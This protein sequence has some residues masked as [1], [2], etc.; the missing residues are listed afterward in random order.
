MKISV[1]ESIDAV[2]AADWNSLAHQD[3]PFLTHE[4]LAALERNQCVG[5]HFGWLPR[6]LVAKDDSGRLLGAVPMYL[7]F[8]SYGEF[9]FDWSWADAYARHGLNYYPKLV[10]GIPYTP[11]TGPR[12]LIHPNFVLD[13]AVMDSLIQYSI[14]YAQSLGVSS[15]HWLFPV[16]ND[17]DYLSKHGLL[18]RLGCQYHWENRAYQDF[19]GFLEQFTSVKRKKVKQERRRV[20][21]AGIKIEV[22]RGLDIDAQHW[23]IF[24]DFYASTF[25]RKGGVATFNRAFFVEV[26]RTMGEGVVLTLA[27]HGTDYVAGALCYQGGGTLHGRH[28]GC[29][30]QFNA[31]HFELC[32]YQGIEFCIAEQLRRFEPGAQGEHKI[33]RGFLPEATWSAHWVAHPAFRAAIADFLQQ[34]QTMMEIQ[35]KELHAHSPYKVAE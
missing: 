29:T 31:L 30:D 5:H 20:Q 32:Y 21:E 13:H 2:A 26:G 12:I 35:M 34:E 23:T 28:W 7:K 16:K 9:V 33:S 17:M 3:N 14:E 11:A 6:H 1:I 10:S 22:L 18:T 27:K 4:F 25:A 19:D 15:L 24:S 8:N